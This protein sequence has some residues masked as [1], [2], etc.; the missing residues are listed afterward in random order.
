MV[1][2]G[3]A[4]IRKSNLGRIFHTYHLHIQQVLAEQSSLNR[5]G[6][7]GGEDSAGHNCPGGPCTLLGALRYSS[8]GGKGRVPKG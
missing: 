6:R 8:L 1:F 5:A 2:F 4:I 3:Y 7:K